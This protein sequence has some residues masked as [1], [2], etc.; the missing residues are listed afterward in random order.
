MNTQT[1]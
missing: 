1:D